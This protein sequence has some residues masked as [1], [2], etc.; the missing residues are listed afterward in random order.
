MRKTENFWVLSAK[1]VHWAGCVVSLDNSVLL[2]T[3]SKSLIQSYSRDMRLVLIFSLEEHNSKYRH[4]YMNFREHFRNSMA[5]NPTSKF[6]THWEAAVNGEFGQDAPCCVTN[7]HMIFED[8]VKRNFY[9]Y[10]SKM[11]SSESAFIRHYYKGEL[12]NE[13]F[14]YEHDKLIFF[15]LPSYL[16][17][18]AQFPVTGDGT[19]SPVRHLRQKQMY[20]LTVQFRKKTN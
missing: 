17:L 5:R 1:M 7:N 18:L 12:L 13:R 16:Q 6:S 9:Y 11:D 15:M 10:N 19:W 3:Y 8:K 4:N 14:I 2:D 20:V